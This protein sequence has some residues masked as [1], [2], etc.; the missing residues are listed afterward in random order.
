[1]DRMNRFAPVFVIV[2]ASL[3]GFDGIVLRPYLANLPVSLVVFIEVTLISFASIPFLIKRFH[4]IKSITTK[5]WLILFGA[6]FF[7]GA[8]G[9]MSIVKALFYVDFVNLSIVVFLQ[10]LQPVFALSL[11]ALL[12]KERLPSKFFL[13]AALAII[14]SFFVTFGFNLPYMETGD[15]TSM[16]AL[17]AIIAAFSFGFATVLGKGALRKVEYS[18][19]TFIRFV[20][21]MLIM[22]TVVLSLGKLSSINEVT[23][24]Q[25][26]VFLIIA[27]GIEGF[28]FYMY[29][30]G[31]QR[32]TA[33]VATICELAFPLTAVL[34]EYLIRGNILGPVQWI[35]GIV[36]FYSIFQVTMISRRNK[37]RRAAEASPESQTG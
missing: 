13:W 33:S 12:L 7:G 28:A 37:R 18:I 26:I 22:L 1:M 11:A 8:I 15:K 17:Y 6:A 27:L 2:A 3:W 31:L 35:G 32:I 29:Y 21:T 24:S 5:Q 14:G 34:L 19:A 20:L 10:K 16:A 30:Y 25:W 9:T 4:T 23:Q 36:L